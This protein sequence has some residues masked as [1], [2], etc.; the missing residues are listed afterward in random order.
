MQ[1]AGRLPRIAGDAARVRPLGTGAAVVLLV[2]V[3]GLA[4]GLVRLLR[5]VGPVVA[6]P[7]GLGGIRIPAAVVR[8]GGLTLLSGLGMCGDKGLARTVAVA[9]GGRL[10]RAHLFDSGRGRLGG[11]RLGLLRAHRLGG[12]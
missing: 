3:N 10:V 4:S 7:A 11:R 1:L 8:L 6:V 2:R 5:G 9:P 12:V